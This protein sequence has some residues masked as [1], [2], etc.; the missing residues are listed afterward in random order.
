MSKKDEKRRASLV[1][2]YGVDPDAARSDR[3]RYNLIRLWILRVL[4]LIITLV[5]VAFAILVYLK[6]EDGYVFA[7]GKK[8]NGE[9]FAGIINLDDVVLVGDASSVTYE[10]LEVVNLLIVGEAVIATVYIILL[11][12]F[13]QKM[14]VHKTELRIHKH[15][16]KSKDLERVS[17]IHKQIDSQIDKSKEVE[18]S[19][20]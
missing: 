16:Y 17:K 15:Y 9:S 8:F 7:V 20:S 11:L 14:A 4:L 2:L 5:F 13:L 12:I 19:E 3:K 18:K 10:W 1:A 6:A